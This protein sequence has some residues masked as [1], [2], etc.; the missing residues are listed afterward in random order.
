MCSSC[1]WCTIW[2]SRSVHCSISLQCRTSRWRRISH[3]VVFSCQCH[4]CNR[5]Q[6]LHLPVFRKLQKGVHSGW[7]PAT[8]QRLLQLMAKTPEVASLYNQNIMQSSMLSVGAFTTRCPRV[9]L[10]RPAL[11][12][13]SVDAGRRPAAYSRRA[14][15]FA[16]ACSCSGRDAQNAGRI[17]VSAAAASSLTLWLLSELPALAETTD[18]SKG[19]FAKESYYVTLGL[20]LISLP[21]EPPSLSPQPVCNLASVAICCTL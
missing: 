6:A 5:V 8:S 13:S 20:F 10:R 21:G 18:F 7:V 14:Q 12:Q 1:N 4:S 2:T 17:P 15:T 3:A 19:G 11:Q 9:P 16:P